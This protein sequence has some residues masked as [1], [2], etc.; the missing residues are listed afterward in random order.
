MILIQKYFYGW[1]IVALAFISIITYGL[2][3]SYS[4]FL[5]LLEADLGGTRAAISAV[6]TIYMIVYC[7]CG[8]PMGL[9]CDKF[10]PRKTL[11]LAALLIGAGI[12]L[13]GFAT[14]VWQLSL[15]FGVIAAIGHGAIYVVPISTINRWFVKRRGL[16]VGIASCGLG[17]GLLVVP[18]IAT[19][20]IALY[21]WRNAFIILGF[22]FLVINGIVGFLLKGKPEDRGLQPLGWAEGNISPVRNLPDKRDFRVTEALRTRAFW[23]LF[24]V[25]LFCFAGEQMVLVHII[26]Y[27]DTIGIPA[28]Q[29]SLGLSALG[30]GTIMGRA[31]TGALSD[32]IGRVPT[33]IMSC[34]IEAGAI[35]YL[36]AIK[37]TTALYLTMLI[38]G[39]GYGSWV[40]LCSVSL[41]DF[42]GLKNLGMI[43]GIWF[44]CGVPSG[45]LGPLLGGIVYD[46][47]GDYFGAFVIAGI[48]CV[49]AAILSA[50]VKPPEKATGG[51]KE[52]PA[53]EVK[54]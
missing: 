51:L 32:R 50:L 15:F 38:L 4:A 17:V 22:A 53:P 47:T 41:G 3:Y 39:F 8:I 2:F 37:D 13:S 35:F 19:R 27:S 6:Y 52:S 7:L 45:V 16:A 29:A 49:V 10:G 43:L 28:A 30:I 26:P 40:V 21:S 18:P 25:S 11:W 24:L 44:A 46:M 36:L 5:V 9:L 14:S 54:I 48:I 31:S 20:L 23:M 34:V 1:V 33:L 42:F 12:I